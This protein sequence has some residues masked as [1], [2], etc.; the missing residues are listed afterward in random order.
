MQML[1]H[2]VQEQLV[3]SEHEMKDPWVDHYKAMAKDLG[4][5]DKTISRRFWWMGCII[6]AIAL[7]R[8]WFSFVR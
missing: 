5:A 7:P 3:R 6:F 2:I 1:N 4:V 8:T